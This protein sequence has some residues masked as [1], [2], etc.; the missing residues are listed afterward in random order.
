MFPHLNLKTNKIILFKNLTSTGEIIKITINLTASNSSGIDIINT[1]LLKMIINETA[2]VLSHIFNSSLLSG[3][4]SSQL[5]I[6]KVN[7][8]FKSGDNQVFNN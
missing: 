2:P 3:I 1:K 4:A 8:V 5:K 7:L 6:A